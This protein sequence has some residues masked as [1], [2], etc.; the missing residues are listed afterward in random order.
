MTE[1]R[2]REFTFGNDVRVSYEPS[3]SRLESSISEARHRE[4]IFREDVRGIAQAFVI[5]DL[6]PRFRGEGGCVK[7]GG[8]FETW[9]SFPCVG[10]EIKN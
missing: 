3:C 10:G 6:N 7:E 9:K 1:A 5:L 4:F 2:D 8:G